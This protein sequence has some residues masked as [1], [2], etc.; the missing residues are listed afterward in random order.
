MSKLDENEVRKLLEEKGYKNIPPETLKEFM[1]SLNEEDEAE[2]GELDVEEE[3]IHEYRPL[4]KPPLKKSALPARREPIKKSN[5][6]PPKPSIKAAAFEDDDDEPAPIRNASSNASPKRESHKRASPVRSSKPKQIDDDETE[7][8]TKR[9]QELRNKAD[10]L[11]QSLQECRDII[12]A[13]PPEDDGA[14]VDVP[15]YFGTSERKLD[16]YPAV[17]KELV[18]GFIRPPPIKPSKRKGPPVPKKGRRLLYEERFPDYVPPPERRRDNLRWSI[19]QKL[20]Y[21]DPAYH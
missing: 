15:M 9:I 13:D 21:S 8:W 20:A 11:D 18:G 1:L 10:Q 6:S 17:K 16:P 5:K 7:K 4:K 14:E 3:E 19:R 2:S 12:M